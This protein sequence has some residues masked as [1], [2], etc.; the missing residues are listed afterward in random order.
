[1]FDRRELTRE[2][3]GLLRCRGEGDGRDAVTLTRDSVTTAEAWAQRKVPQPHDPGPLEKGTPE[4]IGRRTG[5]ILA[6][7]GT[8]ITAEDGTYVLQ[9]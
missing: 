1:M 6:E 2:P 8:P 3:G 4:A 9:G 5:N 7:D